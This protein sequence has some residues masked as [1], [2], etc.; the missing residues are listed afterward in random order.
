MFESRIVRLPVA[1]AALFA[2]FCAAAGIYLHDIGYLSFEAVKEQYSGLSELLLQKPLLIVGGFMLLYVTLLAVWVPGAL[3]TMS[4]TAGALFGLVSGTIIV[5]LASLA[6]SALSFL[7]ARYVLRGWVKERFGRS[8]AFL[9]RGIGSD[10]PFYLLTLRLTSIV[11]PF[12]INIGM[13]L[14]A[15]KLRTFAL[16]SMAGAIPST[17]LYVNAGTQMA[18]I[19]SASDIMSVQLIG[20]FLLLGLIPLAARFAMKR[21]SAPLAA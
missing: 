1:I 16:V 12:I 14:T 2:L 4:F 11:P 17:M 18:S 21:R 5:C 8:L 13:G 10:G 15:M 9:D 3:V 20:S 6:G 7:A 19:E